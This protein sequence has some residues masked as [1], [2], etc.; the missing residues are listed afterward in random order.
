MLI[1]SFSQEGYHKYG[2]R[3]IETTLK[4]WKD[5]TL[6]VYYENGIPSSAPR[7]ERLEYVNL[8]DHQQFR[9]FEDALAKSDP[10]FA[11]IMRTPDNEQAYN[12]RFDAMRFYRKAFCIYHAT[13]AE[14]APDRVAWLDADSYAFADV[15]SN[16][17]RAVLPES[18]YIAHLQRE[19]LYTESGFVVFNTHHPVNKQF[20]RMYIDT[21]FNGAF[22][23]LGEWHDCYV[24]DFAIK[25][26]NVERVNLT[27]DERSDH[28]FNDSVIGEYYDH[29][30]GP[31][32]KEQGKSHE[33][34]LRKTA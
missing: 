9:A 24:L 31:V 33:N 34:E 32:R 20:M 6:R 17:L 8:Y 18:C 7:D 30:K 27:K 28:P 25:V 12:F 29:L 21:Y 15:P 1:T 4:H 26:L 5:E 14:D 13:T 23:L 10:I 2:K 3:F 22:K 11:G 19:W 16:F